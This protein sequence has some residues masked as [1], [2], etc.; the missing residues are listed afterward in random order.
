MGPRTRIS[1][2]MPNIP[3]RKFFDI[4]KGCLRKICNLLLVL[5]TTDKYQAQA[6]N[7]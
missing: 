2:F 1:L 3:K 4:S 5:P 7:L 6:D